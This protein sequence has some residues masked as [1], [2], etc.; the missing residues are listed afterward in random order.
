MSRHSGHT[1]QVCG[2][3]GTSELGYKWGQRRPSWL[4][5]WRRW[6][7]KVL[8]DPRAQNSGLWPY[9]YEDQITE[10]QLAKESEKERARGKPGQ[11]RVPEASKWE[12]R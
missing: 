7:K 1:I 9:K 5:V 12:G 2:A 4:W 8:G 10:D 11:S 3:Q 6:P